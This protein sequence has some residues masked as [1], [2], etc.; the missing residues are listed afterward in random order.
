M[1]SCVPSL[2]E[3]KIGQMCGLT[4]AQIMTAKKRRGGFLQPQDD[5]KTA[6]KVRF[7]APADAP[8]DDDDPD[9]EPVNLAAK[10]IMRVRF[11]KT[12]V[13]HRPDGLLRRREADL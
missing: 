8:D 5:S 9:D 2:R 3:M 6:L 1:A 7:P 11:P 13:E 4:F 12:I 10:P